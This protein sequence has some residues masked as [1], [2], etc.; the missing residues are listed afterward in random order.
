M[1]ELILSE[2]LPIERNPAA[3]YI[4]GLSDGGKRT[5]A[6]SLNVIAGLLTGNADALSCNWAALRFQ[7]TQA[8]R[9]K[10]AEN[11]APSTANKMLSA[12]RGTI[13]AAWQLGQIPG[14][15]YHLAVSVKNISGETVPAGRE[16]SAGE[17]AALIHTCEADPTPA[18]ARDAALIAVMYACGLRRQEVVD[19][20]LSDYEPGEGKLIVRGKRNKQRTAYVLN[21]GSRAMAAWLEVRGSFPG[22]LFV[23]IIKGGAIDPRQMSTQAIYNMLH[24]RADQAGV[25]NFS[26]HD[27]RRTFVSDL[28]DA[29][30][31]ITTVSKMAGHASVNT[32][33]R[34]DRRPETAKKNAANMLHVPYSGR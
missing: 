29:G 6:Q 14:N 3:V 24:K 21:G 1:S 22:P 30:A 20:D 32:T 23:P 11:Y 34:Y 4:S 8:V 28:L 12:M 27:L 31:D 17:L 7:H 19:L 15:D 10:L 9:A 2:Q 26:P 16:L 13:K 5:M 33:A 25:P 18:G